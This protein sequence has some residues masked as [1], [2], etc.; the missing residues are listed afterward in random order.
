MPS[1]INLT[2]E[3]IEVLAACRYCKEPYR[4]IAKVLGRNT[5]TIK[6]MASRIK[7]VPTAKNRHATP[8]EERFIVDNW[9]EMSINRMAG[10][11]NR[12]RIFV[13]NTYER[14]CG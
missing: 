7:E 10:Y 1:P 14:C 6:Q 9:G 8:H 12:S 3:E 13:E 11:L 5:S 4:T 2:P